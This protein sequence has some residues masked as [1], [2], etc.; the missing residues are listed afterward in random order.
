M[1]DE[2]KTAMLVEKLFGGKCPLHSW[3]LTSDH[4]MS[5]CCRRCG[6]RTGDV[7]AASACEQFDPFTRIEDAFA[8]V[9]KMQGAVIIDRGAGWACMVS[10]PHVEHARA[11][12]AA[13][14][15]AEACYLAVSA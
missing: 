9:E 12:T 10:R 8:C 15:I 7:D 4:S 6:R 11:D 5:Q 1:S 2:E 3:H 13:R 14:A